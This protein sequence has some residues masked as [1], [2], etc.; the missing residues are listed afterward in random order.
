MS[1][2]VLCVGDDPS[3]LLLYR[4]ML[5]LK[6]DCALL[7]R[8]VKEGLRMAKTAMIDCVVVDHPTRG[9]VLARKIARR[10]QSRPII[11]VFDGLEIP[12]EIYPDVALIIG[13]DEAIEN[14]SGCIQEV[15]NRR[16]PDCRESDEVE[17]QLDSF[18]GFAPLHR[19]LTDWFLPW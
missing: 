3:A 1:R 19:L 8:D 18:A 10:G 4:S 11:F 16:R 6:G 14:L 12:V 13:R 9:A 17:W 5:E 7:A 2:T 15:L